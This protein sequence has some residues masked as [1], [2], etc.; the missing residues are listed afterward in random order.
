MKKNTDN[1]GKEKASGS[2]QKDNAPEQD[3]KKAQPKDP[4]TID[5]PDVKDI[6]GQEH[7][8]PPRL[9]GLSDTTISSS[10]EEGDAI[11][12]DDDE[13][14]DEDSNISPEE[15]ELLDSAGD[16][17]PD[18]ENIRRNRLDEVD[19]DGD[20]LNEGDPLGGDDLDVPGAD[21]D[22]ADEAIGEEDEA[23]NSYSVDKEN[24]EEDPNANSNI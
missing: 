9:K 20:P 5:L 8:R 15:L 13:L 4:D 3:P 6:P 2:Q 11:F 21:D 10:G 22:D 1:T 14:L 12:N 16:D 18:D 7:I 19:A 17:D 24:E 23:N